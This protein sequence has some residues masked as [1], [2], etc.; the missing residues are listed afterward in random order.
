[1]V[2]QS[3]NTR[4][5]GHQKSSGNL[6]SGAYWSDVPANDGQGDPGTLDCLAGGWAE[7]PNGVSLV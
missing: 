2:R 1:M 3:S 5:R 7:I 6:A 4:G